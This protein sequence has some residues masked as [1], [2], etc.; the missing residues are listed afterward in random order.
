MKTAIRYLIMSA[1]LLGAVSTLLNG[2]ILGCWS[3]ISL[4][5]ISEV[6][7]RLGLVEPEA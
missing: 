5:I 1:M 6:M 3:L 2:Y 4:G 7:F